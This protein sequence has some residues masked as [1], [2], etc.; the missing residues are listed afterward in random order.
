MNIKNKILLY[1]LLTTTL[2]F[3]DV[4]GE[5]LHRI[6]GS[7]VVND[8]EQ[9]YLMYTNDLCQYKEFQKFDK[10]INKFLRKWELKGAS[11]AVIK[12]EKLIYTKGYGWANQEKNTETEPYHLFRIASVSK[13]ITGIAIMKLVEDGQ[14]A[15]SSKVFGKN[16][17]LN[18]PAYTNYI[19]KRVEQITVYNLL[20][21]TGGWTTRWGDQ[22]FIPKSIAKQMNCDLPVDISTIIKFVLSKKLHFT[23]G[24]YYSYSNLGYAILGEVIANISEQSYE[25]YVQNEILLPLGIKNMHIGNSLYKDKDALEV[26]YYEQKDATSVK[27]FYNSDSIVPRSN[28]GNDIKTL[29]S[30]GGWISS[31]P[32]LA[33]LLVSIN[34]KMD[35][36]DILLPETI[37]LMTQSIYNSEG[38]IG[39]KGS[40]NDVWWRTGTLAGTSAMVFK[41]KNDLSYVFI[42]NTSSWKGSDFTIEINKMMHRALQSVS[43]WPE[44]DLFNYYTNFSAVHSI[45]F[46]EIQ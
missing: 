2:L 31:T 18:S 23:P 39:W 9:N 38:P 20:T 41:G 32:E 8:D 13:L 43:F 42:T 35:V 34:N 19:D 26:R 17:I 37:E 29:G 11:V 33:R 25:S 44:Y 40:Y 28:G 7:N 21:H 10:T 30:A 4:A 22:M 5:N 6:S 12:N 27:S 36:P 14:L 3:F 1:F 45:V 24:K 16:G 15:L 46:N